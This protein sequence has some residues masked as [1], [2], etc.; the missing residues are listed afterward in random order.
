MPFDFEDY[1]KKCKSMTKEELH[2][3]WENYTREILGR[4]TSIATSVLLSPL[5][6]AHTA[7]SATGDVLGKTYEYCS[8][9]NSQGQGNPPQQVVQ[10]QI[11]MQGSQPV[12]GGGSG[13]QN[14]RPELHTSQTWPQD[15]PAH[16]PVDRPRHG[17]VP[18][19][20]AV[21]THT[22]SMQGISEQVENLVLQQDLSGHAPDPATPQVGIHT[23]STWPLNYDAHL[24][25][26]GA[27]LADNAKAQN[28]LDLKGAKQRIS[29][30]Q[31]PQ[32]RSQK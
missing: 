30:I 27:N 28:K 32:T 31:I 4:A 5:T 11:Y 6:A 7:L 25:A 21:F 19:P 2:K 16:I 8:R 15:D 23:A 1:E 24:L 9:K 20:L 18:T 3:E 12:L 29:P 13:L 22:S 26:H 17:Y 14:T 10:E